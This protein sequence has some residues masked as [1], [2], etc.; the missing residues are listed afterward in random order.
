M[1]DAPSPAGAMRILGSRALRLALF[2]LGAAIVAS[3]PAV[4]HVHSAFVADGDPPGF[5]EPAAGDHLQST[6]RFC[7]SSATSSR[8]ARRRGSTR[9]ASS[10]SS[11]R[12]PS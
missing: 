4:L 11:S 10:R 2:F 9:T 12:R 7:G 6:Y 1:T 8:R 5:G 3:L